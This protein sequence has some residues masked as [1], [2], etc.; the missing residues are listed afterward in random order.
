MWRIPKLIL[1]RYKKTY[2]LLKINTIT[3]ILLF[4]MKYATDR[5]CLFDWYFIRFIFMTDT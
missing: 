3:N 2:L 1:I 5:G 4:K